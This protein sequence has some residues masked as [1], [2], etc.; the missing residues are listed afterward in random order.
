ME[1]RNV[2]TNLYP[3]KQVSF[4]GTSNQTSKQYIDRAASSRAATGALL[5]NILG[6]GFIGIPVATMILNNPVTVQTLKAVKPLR[7][8]G[9]VAAAVLGA[10]IP[11][12]LAA[13]WMVNHK[14]P[15]E[16]KIS[17][18]NIAKLTAASFVGMG[19]AGALG[20]KIQHAMGDGIFPMLANAIVTVLGNDFAVDAAAKFHN[21]GAQKPE[22]PG[23]TLIKTMRATD[24]SGMN[25][26]FQVF[27]LKAQNNKTYG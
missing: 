26:E 9:A 23:A 12:F 1:I 4:K 3:Q 6:G 22:F 25:Q 7:A 21:K 20:N 13:K 16:N 2:S 24:A 11:G 15:E 18:T 5:G 8:A 19:I 17:N 27:M 14:R 10:V